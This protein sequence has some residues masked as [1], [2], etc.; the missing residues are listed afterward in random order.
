MRPTESRPFTELQRVG[1]TGLFE[2]DPEEPD[3]E[4]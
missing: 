3:K 4:R 1:T 2:V